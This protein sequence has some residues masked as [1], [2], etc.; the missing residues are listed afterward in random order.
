M[1][2][3]VVAKPLLTD[4]LW[5]RIEPFI[6]HRPLNHRVD[7]HRSGIGSVAIRIRTSH[8]Q[9]TS[10]RPATV[11]GNLRLV[12]SG[13]LLNDHDRMRRLRTNLRY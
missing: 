11:N 9:P 6:P 13:G 1:E 2:D 12:P 4:E 7:V 5:E 8:A 10:D 3:M